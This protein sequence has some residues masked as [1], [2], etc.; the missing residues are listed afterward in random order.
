MK[1]FRI[2]SKLTPVELKRLRVVS[3]KAKQKG[4]LGLDFLRVGRLTYA[5][6]GD[7]NI[8]E[9]ARHAMVVAG[10]CFDYEIMERR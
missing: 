1:A 7:V 3:E 10:R 9:V 5:G 8:H 2:T 4:V 6:W